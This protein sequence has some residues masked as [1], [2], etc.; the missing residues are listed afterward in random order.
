MKIK[1]LVAFFFVS[2]LVFSL[3]LVGLVLVLLDNQKQ[4]QQNQQ[5]RLESVLLVQKFAENSDNLTAMA[6]SYIITGELDYKKRYQN[7]LAMRSNNGWQKKYLVR[8][9]LE[10]C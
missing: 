2:L 8:Q 7:L 9:L 5:Q 10:Q 3:V 4:L 1:H 6:K